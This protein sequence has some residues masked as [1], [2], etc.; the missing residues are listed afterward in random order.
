MQNLL[1]R[2]RQDQRVRAAMDAAQTQQDVTIGNVHGGL[3]PVLL[4]AMRQGFGPTGPRV[5]VCPDP[6]GLQDDLEALGLNAAILPELE[7]HDDDDGFD[8]NHELLGKR[9]RACE[10]WAAGHTLLATSRAVEQPVPK[11]SAIQESSIE[12]T[13]GA[14]HDLGDLAETL[15]D[16]GYHVSPLVEEPGDLSQRGGVL[17]I[18]PWAAELPVRLEF[19]DD[20]VESIRRFEPETQETVSKLAS[21]RFT[22]P[23]SAAGGLASLWDELDDQAIFV[24][25]DSPPAATAQTGSRA[26]RNSPR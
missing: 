23:S 6:D 5:V 10:A 20:E 12:I 13:P 4:A 26:Q 15:C 2:Y 3:F 21:V 22:N 9:L 16:Q 24:L 17:D 25:G 11:L 7:D 14:C 19:F 8:S 18:W 1:N